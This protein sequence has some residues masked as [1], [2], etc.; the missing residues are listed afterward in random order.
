MQVQE[1]RNALKEF[2]H[3]DLVNI[4]LTGEH[5]HVFTKEFVETVEKV[6]GQLEELGRNKQYTIDT[7]K[8]KV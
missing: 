2:S 6:Y 1:R 3:I 4:V 5:N 7:L 8:D